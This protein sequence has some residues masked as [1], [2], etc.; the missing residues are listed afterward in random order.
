MQLPAHLVEVEH[1]KE[2]ALE[3]GAGHHQVQQAV[4]QQVLGGLAVGWGGWLGRLGTAAG[5]H[6]LGLASL[7]EALSLGSGPCTPVTLGHQSPLLSHLEVVGQLLLQ[8]LLNHTPPSK[9]DDGLGLGDDDVAQHTCVQHTKE[10]S[11]RSQGQVRG[12]EGGTGQWY[13]MQLMNSH[14]SLAAYQD[15]LTQAL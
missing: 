10:V 9:A 11:G 15:M 6:N 5:L 7:Q 14:A 4:L 3:E 12:R 2:R 8:G 13:P 1:L